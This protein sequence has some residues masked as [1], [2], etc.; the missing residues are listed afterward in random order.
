MKISKPLPP[1][2]LSTALL[3][4]AAIVF[5]SALP[6]RAQHIQYPVQSS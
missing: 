2:V 4:L 1:V 5:M 6:A 3:T